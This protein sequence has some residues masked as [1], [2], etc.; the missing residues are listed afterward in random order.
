MARKDAEAA[1]ARR[2]LVRKGQHDDVLGVL[3]LISGAALFFGPWVAGQMADA[4]RDAFIN[5][6][7]VGLIVVFV[8]GSRL[9]S[10]GGIRNDLV[11]LLAGGWM[12]AGPFLL[13]LGNT[14]VAGPRPFDLFIG[15]VL[16][17]LAVVGLGLLRAS[18]R[19]AP[20]VRH[21]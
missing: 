7:V 14:R 13:G 18:R 2:R 3:M 15:I 20:R 16:S 5:E 12:I 6:L 4:D 10:G 8:A 9:S 11:I 19:P 17:V 21:A 1:D